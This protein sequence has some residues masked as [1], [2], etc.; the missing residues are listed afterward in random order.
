MPPDTKSTAYQSTT[1]G[2]RVRIKKIPTATDAEQF[3]LSRFRVGETYEVGPRLAEYL[4][5]CGY[6]EPVDAPP[7][8]LAADKPKKRR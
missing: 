8:D 4:M 2:V 3:D 7:L 1:L 5:V 6:A